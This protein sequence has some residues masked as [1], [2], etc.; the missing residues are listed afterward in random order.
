[1]CDGKPV[2]P[3]THENWGRKG[4]RTCPGCGRARPQLTP[5]TLSATHSLLY[6][7]GGEHCLLN[8]CFWPQ[9]RNG[10]SKP[11]QPNMSGTEING[12]NPTG[13]VALSYPRADSTL[14][15]PWLTRSIFW[16]LSLPDPRSQ[17]HQELPYPTAELRCHVG[18][19]LGTASEGDVERGKGH[20]PVGCEAGTAQSMGQEEED[21]FGTSSTQ[22]HS[23]QKK[24]GKTAT[25][26]KLW[27]VSTFQVLLKSALPSHMRFQWKINTK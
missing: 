10:E 23:V 14:L 11:I 27:N 8:E 15:S 2:R 18:F 21:R 13:Q 22:Q 12:M 26:R 16:H 5:A 20:T 9:P 1:M 19:P 25:A 24:Q 3:W 6:A 17:E 7:Q 4:R